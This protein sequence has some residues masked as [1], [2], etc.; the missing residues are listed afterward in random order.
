MKG[1][2][3]VRFNIIVSLMFIVF[4]I[5]FFFCCLFWKFL[6]KFVKNK[7]LCKD[8]RFFEIWNVLINRFDEINLRFMFFGF[9]NIRSSYYVEW[10]II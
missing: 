9:R 5:V 8:V 2:G 10:R 1:L 4:Y 6:L 7:V 3:L